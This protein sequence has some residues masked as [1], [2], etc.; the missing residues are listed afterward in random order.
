L[1]L[2]RINGDKMKRFLTG[3]AAVFMFLAGAF[4]VS[5]ATTNF[6]GTWV[7]D[8]AKSQGLPPQIE[9]VE[10][11]TMTVTQDDQQL[12]VETKIAGGGR[13]GG[14]RRPEGAG[15]DPGRRP[16]GAGG[17]GG[18]RPDGG[19]SGGRGGRGGFGM[20]M[21][22]ATYKLD[23]T[24]NKI[25]STGGRGG[26]ATL[27]AQWKDSG[28]ALELS[29]TRTFNV[30]GNEMTRTTKDHWELA[31]GGKT[32]KV[33]RAAEGPQGTQESTLVFTKQ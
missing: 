5:A 3:F 28:K 29:T 31:D 33:K 10:S 21:P 18:R 9:N 32:L 17:Q 8:K 24:E 7:L 15:G 23:G 30:Q 16:E 11:Y 20:G 27:K 2:I 19:G 14:D 26:A 12:T 22:A 6:S 13:P 1:K 25:E 4:I